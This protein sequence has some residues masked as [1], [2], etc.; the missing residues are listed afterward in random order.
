MK[1]IYL[2]FF[3][4][5]SL[6]GGAVQAQ[7]SEGGLPW[8]MSRKEISGAVQN[9]N[10]VQLSRPDYEALQKEDLQD[11]LSGAAKPYRVAAYALTDIDLNKGTWT[12]L[13]DGSK[14]WQV[15]IAVPD[16][17]A[18]AVFYDKFNL[19]EG[20]QLFLTNKA[21]NQ[22]LGAYTSEN[23][24]EYGNFVNEEVIGDVVNLEM[25]IAANVAVKD[26]KFHIDKVTAY[27]RGVSALVQRFGD[28]DQVVA[29]RPTGIGDASSCHV[30][31]NC[32][33]GSTEPGW[34][35]S[36]AASVQI[37]MGNGLCS[38]TLINNTANTQGGQCTPLVLLA[39]HCEGSNST[40]NSTFSGWVFKFNFQS[41]SC[42]GNSSNDNGST[43]TGATFKA[44]SKFPSFTG[45]SAVAD[46]LLVQMI[47]NPPTTAYLA[48]WNRNT[49]LAQNEDYPRFIG[50]HHP[51]GDLKKLVYIENMYANGSFN[52]TAVPNT[53]WR[54]FALNASS[55]GTEGG[56]SGSGLFDF[57]GLLIGDLSGGPGS[58][59]PCAPMGTEADYCKLSYA[60]EN[61]FDQT[62]TPG[63]ASRLKD[64]LD[65]INTGAMKCSP[66]SYNCDDVI[67]GIDELENILDQS[68]ALYPNPVTN[69]A[70]TANMNFAEARDLN[71]TVF[72]INGAKQAQFE[73]KKVRS[74]K[75]AFDLSALPSGVYLFNVASEGASISRKIVITK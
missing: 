29:A 56:S 47:G 44:R 43:R 52:Q 28:A 73:V 41:A 18:I 27:Y 17:K 46:F 70:I 15:S 60:W 14:I 69:G 48:G 32:P 12:Y 2:A 62:S 21:G 19:P 8:S 54:T 9:A 1:K 34:A 42:E 39:S 55:G 25:N 51:A 22:I 23:N 74:G 36:K 24:S 59:G 50:F 33:A 20:V 72:N 57:E 10:K 53:H 31:A 16:A 75:Y 4:A 45:N 11:A 63:A 35:K 66:A 13:N 71:I 7:I 26:I 49:N 30:N 67:V 37:T 68:V 61:Q 3:L 38:G 5:C 65:P 6:G 40:D 64:W 58:S